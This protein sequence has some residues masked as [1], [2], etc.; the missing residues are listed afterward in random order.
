MS[1]NGSDR[2]SLRSSGLTRH[3]EESKKTSL[4][5][6]LDINR[7]GNYLAVLL[8]RLVGP[9]DCAHVVTVAADV[10]H[11]A[12]LFDSIFRGCLKSQ[13]TSFINYWLSAFK[14]IKEI[15]VSDPNSCILVSKSLAYI[16]VVFD[17]NRDMAYLNAFLAKCP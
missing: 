4:H 3:R 2:L 11:F 9:N 8:V 7:G 6:G 10:Q 14:N 15:R 13:Y 1:T 12:L 17:N 5:L 16:L